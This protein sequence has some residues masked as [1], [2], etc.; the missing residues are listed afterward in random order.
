LLGSKLRSSE[1]TASAMQQKSKKA[2]F[3]FRRTA[4]C[5]KTN[6]YDPHLLANAMSK[7]AVAMVLGEPDHATKE[8]EKEAHVKKEN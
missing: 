7:T 1:A 6:Y 4:I 8:A 5:Y 3:Q 2:F